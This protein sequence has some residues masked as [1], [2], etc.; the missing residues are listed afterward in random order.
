MLTAIFVKKK[1]KTYT[2]LRYDLHVPI[3]LYS[4]VNLYSNQIILSS[5]NRCALN[6][7][8]GLLTKCSTNKILSPQVH[9][10]RT[11]RPFRATLE[12]TQK[13]I[14]LITLYDGLF[15][16]TEMLTMTTQSG[17]KKGREGRRAGGPGWGRV[18]HTHTHTQTHSLTHSP[19]KYARNTAV[20]ACMTLCPVTLGGMHT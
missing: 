1:T 8:H 18:K 14:D 17:L 11:R 12:S 16:S 13:A 4:P 10:Q 9:T 20:E 7:I 19:T 2:R 6:P 5:N 3:S 15:K